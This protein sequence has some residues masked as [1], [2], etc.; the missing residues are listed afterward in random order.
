MHLEGLQKVFQ[1]HLK[2][3]RKAIKKF[4]RF[5]LLAA[6]LATLFALKNLALAAKAAKWQRMSGKSH[7]CGSVRWFLKGL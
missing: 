5:S 2:S 7:A 1:R 3:L 6:T 4:L